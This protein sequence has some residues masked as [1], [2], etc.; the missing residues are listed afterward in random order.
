[1]QVRL[2]RVYNTAVHISPL[3]LRKSFDMDPRSIKVDCT[4]IRVF[5]TVM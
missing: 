5:N 2:Q 3:H 4:S 1:M